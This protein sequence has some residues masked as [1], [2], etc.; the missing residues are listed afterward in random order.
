MHKPH[1]TPI[2]VMF[3]VLICIITSACGASQSES[4]PTLSVEAIQTSAVG[5]YSIGLTLTA[6]SMPTNTALPT[7]TPSPIN[8]PI[9]TLLSSSL[10]PTMSCYGLLWLK[11]ETVPDNTPMTPGQTFTKT[12]LVQNTG[13]CAWEAGFKFAYI[14]GDAMGSSTLTLTKAVSPGTQIELSIPMTAPSTPGSVT[15]RWRMS[16]SNGVYFGDWLS[17][18]IAITGPT[19]TETETPTPTLEGGE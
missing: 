19:G 5:T 1:K 18:V 12:W 2:R 13:T 4:T 9:S 16:T 17:V 14:G 15:S 3:A 6:L 11:V 8:T 7:L 10:T